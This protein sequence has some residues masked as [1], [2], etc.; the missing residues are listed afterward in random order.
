VRPATDNSEN[1]YAQISLLLRVNIGPAHEVAR[2]LHEKDPTNAT[3]ASTYA[4]SLYVAGHPEEAVRV[5]ASLRPEDLKQPALAAYYGIFLAAA[6]DKARAG[7]Y[8]E[9]GRQAHLLP[10]EKALLDKASK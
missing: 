2:K 3:F 4:F 1:N 9:L 5:M 7:T 8:L 6:G 10:E